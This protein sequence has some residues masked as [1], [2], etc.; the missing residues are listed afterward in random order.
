MTALKR[1]RTCKRCKREMDKHHYFYSP[2]DDV[3]IEC[4]PDVNFLKQ[5][6]RLAREHG[7]GALEAKFLDYIRRARLVREVMRG[8][9]REAKDGSSTPRQT[10]R[11]P[12]SA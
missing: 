10:T 2:T 12:P 1:T 5:S 8:L 3:C 9:R 4:G 6:K 7:T 11:R